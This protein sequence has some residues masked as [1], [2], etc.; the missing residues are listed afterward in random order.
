MFRGKRYKDAKEKLGD[1]ETF[2]LQEA[3]DAVTETAKAKFDESVDVALKLG[4]DPRHAEQMVRGTL[5]LPHGTG[6]NV[7]VLVFAKGDK[8][9]EAQEAGADYIGGEDLAKKIQGGWLEFDKA[10]ATPD[11]MNVVGKLGRIL[12]PRGMMPTP[13]AGTVTFD[14]AQAVKDIKA[15]KVEFRVD[16]GGIIHVAMGR[17]SFGKEKLLENIQAFLDEVIKLKPSSSKG[18]YLRKFSLSSTMGPGIKVDMGLLRRQLK[19]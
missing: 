2:N 15:G 16:K 13:K 1:K 19:V 10:A 7:R 9:K 11:M 18:Q 4:V 14:I 3:L 5:I 12:G 8:E 6:K 17:V